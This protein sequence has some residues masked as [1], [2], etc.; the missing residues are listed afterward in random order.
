[1]CG[2]SRFII[3]A[4][5]ALCSGIFGNFGMVMSMLHS[6]ANSQIFCNQVFEVK[7]CGHFPCR[8][9]DL[10]PVSRYRSVAEMIIRSLRVLC[11]LIAFSR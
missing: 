2:G 4:S 8:I 9:G 1:M 11:F 3:N 6:F 10:V 5:S 7:Y